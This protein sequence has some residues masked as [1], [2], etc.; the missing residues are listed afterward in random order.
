MSDSNGGGAGEPDS[1]LSKYQEALRR[2]K[3]D[4]AE[5]APELVAA[6]APPEADPAPDNAAPPEPAEDSAMSFL[7]EIAEEHGLGTARSSEPAS[8]KLAADSAG[9]APVAAAAPVAEDEK[10][11]KKSDNSMD[12][13]LNSLNKLKAEK[14]AEGPSGSQ[15]EAEDEE[16]GPADALK[17]AR[18][19][20]QD[21]A[22]ASEVA[23]EDSGQAVD[24]R[25]QRA[26]ERLEDRPA[27]QQPAKK[28]L[29]RVPAL[30][31]VLHADEACAPCAPAAGRRKVKARAKPG[32][33]DS[34]RLT[35]LPPLALK[36]GICL[37]VLVAGLLLQFAVYLLLDTQFVFTDLLAGC[38]AM[39]PVGLVLAMVVPETDREWYATIGGVAALGL[40]ASLGFALCLAAGI[41]EALSEVHVVVLLFTQLGI[42]TL[43]LGPAIMIVAGLLHRLELIELTDPLFD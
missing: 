26:A 2:L 13:Y 24:T 31:G 37:A 43:L 3:G 35:E 29:R 18:G 7:D 21:S 36:A 16:P 40:V 19:M 12:R 28:K 10:P 30:K 4:A 25:F 32:T 33:P 14:G 5:A 41:S 15:A 6:P 34:S 38:A 9:E 39:L 23:A 8:A 1:G 27:V 22:A 17:A 42:I 20:L 11:P